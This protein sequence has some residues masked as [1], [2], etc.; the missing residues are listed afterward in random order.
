V[1]CYQGLVSLGPHVNLRAA[2]TL[3]L[4]GCGVEGSEQTEGP[5]TATLNV[6]KRAVRV[7]F[8]ETTRDQ[9]DVLDLAKCAD[10]LLMVMTPNTDKT[11]VGLDAHGDH[12]LTIIK[13]QG[14]PAVLGAVQALNS[15]QPKHQSF[16]KKQCTRYLHTQFPHEPKMLALDTSADA[17]QVL[18]Y[19]DSESIPELRWRDQRAYM[20]VENA[21]FVPT[22]QEKGTLKLSGYLRG[23]KALTA[24]HLIHLTGFADFQLDGIEQRMSAAAAAAKLGGR[25]KGDD[26]LAVLPSL[27]VFY[28]VHMFVN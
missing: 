22:D 12:L 28:P 3:L 4:Q 14:V 7:T 11:D 9:V 26:A 25:I 5:V 19:I 24:N 15:V 6:G 17:Q 8:L 13:S 1:C 27:I 10:L 21:D 16:I 20:L 18:R 2:R 23:T